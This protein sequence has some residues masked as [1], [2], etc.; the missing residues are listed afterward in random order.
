M[1][2]A[3]AGLHGQR[4][5]QPEKI[6]RAVADAYESSSQAAHASVQT[7]AVLALFPDFK[8]QINLT[9]FFVNMRFGDIGILRLEL[10][11]IPQ[12]IQSQ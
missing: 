6:V 4:L 5:A 11:E 7:N 9:V 8:S 3:D 2:V 12:L 1:A 10:L